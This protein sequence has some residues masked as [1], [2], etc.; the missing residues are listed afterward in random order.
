[1]E[2]FPKFHAVPFSKMLTFFRKAP[3]ALTARYADPDVSRI[4]RGDQV[5]GQCLIQGVKPSAQG[6][7]QKVKVK[8]RV[9]AHGV[10]QVVSATLMEKQ[11]VWKFLL[12]S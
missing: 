2:V 6:E 1:M 9:N 8:V 12:Y 11:Q 4:H 10:F 7:V 3:F 5:V